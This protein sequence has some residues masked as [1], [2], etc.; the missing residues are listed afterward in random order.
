M[1]DQKS[2]RALAE[3]RLIE[4]SAKDPEFRNRLLNN[5]K[6]TIEKEAGIKFPDAVEITVLE[7]GPKTF[8]L[9]LPAAV[10]GPD[11]SELT[12]QELA[13]VAGAGDGYSIAGCEK[14]YQ[15]FCKD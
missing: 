9:V 3:N 7:E 5:P 1:S 13:A 4:K 15:L 6:E 12:E 11:I 14:T 10:P 8:F 2:L